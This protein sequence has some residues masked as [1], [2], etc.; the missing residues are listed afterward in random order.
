MRRLRFSKLPTWWVRKGLLRTAFPGGGET[1]TSIAALKC[2]I[3]I[4]TVID[5]HSC[6]GHIPF[7]RLEDVTGLSRPMVQRGIEA[8]EESGLVKVDRGYANEYE[9]IVDSDDVYWAKL[10]VNRLIKELA[11]IPNRGK[12]PLAALKIYL[13]LISIR[14]NKSLH[15]SMSY[16]SFF[17]ELGLQRSDVR[18]ALNILYSDSLL[19]VTRSNEREGKPNVYTILGLDLENMAT[20]GGAV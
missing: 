19:H 4:S 18:A 14:P 17:K 13:T 20:A 8:L 5:F 11:G 2:L 12:V 7:T 15:V 6:R 16:D 1:G 10:P 9:L 3:A